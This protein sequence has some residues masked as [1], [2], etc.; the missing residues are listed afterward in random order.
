MKKRLKT[1]KNLACQKFPIFSWLAVALGTLL[2]KYA[3]FVV[4][5]LHKQIKTA[6]IEATAREGQSGWTG[7]WSLF[8]GEDKYGGR[9]VFLLFRTSWISEVWER[10]DWKILT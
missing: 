3:T 1:I 4:A 7:S 2:A 6:R 9:R 10:V 5:G 8:S